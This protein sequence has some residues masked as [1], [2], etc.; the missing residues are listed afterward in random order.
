MQHLDD[1]GRGHHV[2]QGLVETG[3]RPLVHLLVRA[4]AAVDLHDKRLGSVRIGV[5][6]RATEGLGPVRGESLLVLRME[7][8]AERVAD[9]LVG[10]R[11]GVPR[12]GQAKQTII[13]PGGL[14]YA[15]HVP[16][17]AGPASRPQQT[18]DRQPGGILLPV[19]TSTPPGARTTL[20]DV[21]NVLDLADSTGTRL[22]IDG[23]WGVDAL[24]GQQSREH[25]DLDIA[26]E[27]RHL[28][29][30]LDTLL[31]NGFERI[32]EASAPSWNFL[33][34]HPG[35]AVVD[36][37]VIVLD[38]HGNGVLSPP[39]QGN[40]YPAASLTGRGRVGHRTV[41]CIAAEWVIRFHDAYPGDADDRADVQALCERF[42][43]PI[44][45]QYR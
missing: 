10:H 45:E 36:L 11:P 35:G 4:V 39:E 1:V 15:L 27:L 44:P 6:G 38:A 13:A 8:V 34:A 32:D 25:A 14:I 29:P 41:D 37:H 42:G 7:A 24:L 5:R 18:H 43:L 31:H 33:L 26:V 21:L 19:A 22:W 12:L 9:H 28:A 3:D 20:D 17:M 23:G 16:R 2:L 40:A 30:F